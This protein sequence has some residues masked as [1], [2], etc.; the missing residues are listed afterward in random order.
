MCLGWVLLLPAAALPWVSSTL[1]EPLWVWSHPKDS[2]WDNQGTE[3]EEAPSSPQNSE[4]ELLQE[5]GDLHPCPTQLVQNS[6]S[7]SSVGSSLQ[8]RSRALHAEFQSL[9]LLA[10]ALRGIPPPQMFD[11]GITIVPRCRIAG[12][13]LVFGESISS[14]LHLAEFA[15]QRHRQG[16]SFL[17]QPNPRTVT[18]QAKGKMG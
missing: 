17:S 5:S 12:L 9:Q 3:A 13:V 16:N 8:L 18:A 14:A 1:V 11:H 2:L 7:V 15:T 10:I 6:R 4:Q